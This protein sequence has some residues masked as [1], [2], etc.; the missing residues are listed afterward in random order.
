[1]QKCGN[2]IWY[3]K[4]SCFSKA[5]TFY[6]RLTKETHPFAL[7]K[8]L[9]KPH[10]LFQRRNGRN[11]KRAKKSGKISAY[12]PCWTT[13]TFFPFWLTLCNL[14][15]KRELYSIWCVGYD[16]YT[17]SQICVKSN[18]VNHVTIQY[19]FVTV[20]RST[21][22]VIYGKEDTLNINVSPKT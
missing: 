6:T 1:M 18:L 11:L 16:L 13:S 2:S 22:K 17:T 8:R 9:S 5:Q 21:F 19:H 14:D 10:F 4:K 7:L 3:A 20:T 12:L 15:A